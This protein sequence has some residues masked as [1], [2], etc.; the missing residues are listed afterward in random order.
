MKPETINKT[1]H[2]VSLLTCLKAWNTHRQLFKIMNRP[3]PVWIQVKNLENRKTDV[4]HLNQI[5]EYIERNNA[6]LTVEFKFV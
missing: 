1:K 2:C 6:F 3:K 4:I 5:P